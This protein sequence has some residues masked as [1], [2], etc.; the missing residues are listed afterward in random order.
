M[1]NDWYRAHLHDHTAKIY[2]VDVKTTENGAEISV[3]Q[4]FGQ[5][6]YDPFA[7]LEVTYVISGSYLDIY[8]EAEMS[9]KVKLLPR[10]GIR[11]FV[12]KR[13]D[14]V[15]YF[16]YGPYESYADKH[17][18]SYM[19]NFSAAV[20]EMHEDYVRPQENSSHFNCEHM[21]FTDG[22]VRVRFDGLFSFNASEYTQ[23]ELYTKAH[24]FELEKC[25]SNVFCVDYKMA[26][27]GSNA[28]GPELAEKYRIE[29]PKLKAEFHMSVSDN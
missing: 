29:L 23:E 8:C 28:C 3:K 14:S 2:N 4:S 9:E 6:V 7:R 18:A 19:G 22:S 1:K 20:S 10:F 21:S 15:E 13:F 26:G 11:M 16:G 12:P 24:N 17:H 25:E 27:I 5:N